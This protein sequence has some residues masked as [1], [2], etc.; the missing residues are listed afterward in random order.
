MR[1]HVADA[2]AFDTEFSKL[3]H[4]E[5]PLSWQRRLYSR[6]LDGKLPAALDLPTGLG[7]TSVMALRLPSKALLAG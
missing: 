5:A 7:K 4:V 6:L 1:W 2:A 3:V